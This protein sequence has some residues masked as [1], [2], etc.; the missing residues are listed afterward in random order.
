MQAAL[1]CGRGL[2]QAQGPSGQWWWHYDSL[3]GR[4]LEGY[5]VFSVH[6]HAMGPMT[7]FA[8]GEAAHC[9]FTPW[10]YRGLKWLNA[11][12]ELGFN[13]EDQSAQVIWRCQYM[14][15]SH[16][17]T[18]LRAAFNLVSEDRPYEARKDLK[19]L[20]ECRPYE[21]G[22]LLYAFAARAGQPSPALAEKHSSTITIAQ[23]VVSG[24]S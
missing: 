21:L 14:P 8:L 3:T 6:Q 11:E 13:M 5:P 16:V 10:I 7:L 18:Y 9:D 17:T 4:V 15:T 24:K 12:N 20:F 19:V 2:C 23:S 1:Q 22:W